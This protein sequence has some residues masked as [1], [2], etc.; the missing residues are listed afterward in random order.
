M[1]KSYF[2]KHSSKTKIFEIEDFSE[3][4][5][6]FQCQYASQLNEVIPSIEAL[7]FP[8]SFDQSLSFITQ[9]SD[10]VFVAVCDE[11]APIDE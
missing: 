7:I 2:S 11:N 4:N 8:C 6:T 9:R 10:T 3:I 5:V 1:T